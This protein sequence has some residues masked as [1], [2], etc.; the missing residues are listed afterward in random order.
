M[1]HKKRQGLHMWQKAINKGNKAA[2]SL[3]ANLKDAKQTC[4]AIPFIQRVTADGCST[5]TV[6]NKLCFGQCSSLFVPYE[7]DLAAEGFRQRPPCSRCGPSKT[8]AVTV[9]LQCGTEIRHTQVMLVQECKCESGREQKN[10][11]ESSPHV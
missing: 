3:P 6:H 2:V 10:A 9:P 4:A 11:E 1:E 5:V 7:V 8:H